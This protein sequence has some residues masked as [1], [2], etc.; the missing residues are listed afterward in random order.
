M[1][2]AETLEARRKRLLWRASRRGIREMDLLVGGYAASHLPD[3]AE[4]DLSSFEKLL[5]IPD[6]D[7]LAYA[8][9]QKEIPPGLRSPLLDA[10]LAFRIDSAP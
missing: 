5:D 9:R 1:T 10:V 2:L 8:T 3:M 6:Q 7:L 4:A